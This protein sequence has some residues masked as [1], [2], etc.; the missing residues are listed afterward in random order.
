M[1][2]AFDPPLSALPDDAEVVVINTITGPRT[3]RQLAHE[4]GEGLGL[5]PH[6]LTDLRIAVHELATNTIPHAG[7]SGLLSIWKAGNHLVVQ[8]DD[9]SR[10]TD[11]LVGAALLGPRRSVTG[12]TSSTRSPTSCACTAPA[13]APACAPTSG[14]PDR[15][16]SARRPPEAAPPT[17]D[18]GYGL[19]CRSNWRSS[20]PGRCSCALATHQYRRRSTAAGLV[21]ARCPA[22]P[23]GLASA[24]PRSG[25][26]TGVVVHPWWWPAV[27]PDGRVGSA[28]RCDCG[29]ASGGQGATGLCGSP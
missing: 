11:P 29:V 26:V 19:A 24:C 6:R 25:A 12:Y 18:N 27:I 10:I 20:E 4:V 9:G 2:A 15:T 5:S 22:H 14:T 8:I 1:A 23:P 3:A 13:T 21:A 16:P 17:S 28:A 7:G